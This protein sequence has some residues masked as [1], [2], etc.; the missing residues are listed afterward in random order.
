MNAIQKA[1]TLLGR[2][3]RPLGGVG[4]AGRQ[5]APAPRR[6]L[7]Q[8]DDDPRRRVHLERAGALRRRG[9]HDLPARER[10]R[11]R[12]RVDPARR[13]RAG[14]VAGAAA[15][16]DWLAEH[17]PSWSW[18]TDYPPS[19]IDPATPIIGA[20][21]RPPAASS[22]SRSPPRGSTRRTTA[23]SSRASPEPRAR[24]SARATSHGR[25][26]PTS[27]SES[28]SSSTVRV[29]ARVIWRA[30]CG[31]VARLV[32]ARCADRPGQGPRRGETD[33][34]FPRELDKAYPL[35]ERA[36]GVWLYD[37]AGNAI[38]DA[39]GGGRDGDEPRLRRP[40]D[41]RG[42]ARAGRADLP[43]STTSARRARPRRRSPTS[44]SRSLRR[45]SP[46]STSSRAAPRRTS[47]RCGS[48]GA[49]TSS[50]AS[51]RA[52]ASSRPRRP[53]T[54]RP[55]RRCRLPAGR[56]SSTRTSPTSR[57]QLHIPPSTW[58]FD[59]S[60]EA[61]LE[62]LDRAIEEAGPET[63]AGFFCEAVSAAAL[64]ALLAARALLARARGAPPRA[65]VPRLLRRGRHRARP[66]RAPGSPP[67]SCPSC[68]T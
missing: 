53:I 12:L 8:P 44:S 54:A 2:A 5:A 57:P 58:R 22:A 32:P 23:L 63:I 19:E 56:G 7:G 9:Q 31:V 46:A 37:A 55:G 45:A 33:R 21:R 30:R 3:R 62:A 17:P 50:A 13:D 10:R 67:T 27:G 1:A 49:T 34:V 42:G 15:A 38:L 52:G 4:P 68:R 40:G 39:V 65:R 16:D 43:S 28:T 18:Y 14:C 48:P 41:H 51:R 36:E 47:S 6:A 24:R 35:I 61:A 60:G 25:M 64:P 66:D 29:Y 59:P 11:G 20:V 26:R